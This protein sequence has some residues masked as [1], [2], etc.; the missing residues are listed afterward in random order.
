MTALQTPRY[1]PQ[2]MTG[3]FLTQIPVP[4]KAN[5]TLYVGGIVCVDASGYAVP[6]AV[7]TT[8]RAVGVLQTTGGL[9]IPGPAL[10]G[11]AVNGTVTAPVT[12]GAAFKVDND[13]LDPIS[14]ADV[15]KSCYL[16]DNQT[17]CRTSGGSTKSVAGQ[18]VGVDGPDDDG[19]AGVWVAFGKTP[20]D[21]VGVAGP[22]GAV[23]PTG[24]TGPRGPTGPQGAT[25]P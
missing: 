7:S 10:L 22:T 18:V 16:T 21:L 9:G 5:A 17:V 19:G 3:D 4:V 1:T 25:G 8:L 12:S 11:G 2:R 23:G 14:Q 24:P 13:P 15:M 6:A 20:A